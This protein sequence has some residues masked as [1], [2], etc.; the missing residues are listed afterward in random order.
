MLVDVV[1]GNGVAL[2]GN[3]ALFNGGAG[4][5]TAL[6]CTVERNPVRSNAGHG[7]DLGSDSADRENVIS[8]NAGGTITGGLNLGDNA[9]NGTPTCP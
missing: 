3:T 7:L 4:I 1:A 8:A 5:R 6:G 9:C 2:S